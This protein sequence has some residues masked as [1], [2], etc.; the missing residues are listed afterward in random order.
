M[1]E[2]KYRIIGLYLV[3]QISLIFLKLIGVSITWAQVF[4]VTTLPLCILGISVGVF[5]MI[6]GGCDGNCNP[7]D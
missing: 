3:L 2:F 1:R 5:M 6:K 7:D 4:Y